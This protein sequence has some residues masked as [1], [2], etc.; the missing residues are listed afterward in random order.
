[1][2]GEVRLDRQRREPA[3]ERG[4]QAG[5]RGG[6][7]AAEGELLFSQTKVMKPTGFLTKRGA[8]LNRALTGCRL[9]LGHCHH[10]PGLQ[11]PALV[12]RCEKALGRQ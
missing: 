9:K 6:R 5:L 10:E 3:Q 12:R 4:G 7:G 8:S 1:M 11:R 2:K